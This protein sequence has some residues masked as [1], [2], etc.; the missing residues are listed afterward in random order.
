MRYIIGVTFI[1]FTSIAQSANFQ[2]GV[3]AY[4]KG[5]FKMAYEEFY[6]LAEQGGAVAQYNIG[7]MHENGKAVKQDSKQAVHWYLKAAEQ[8]NVMA[9]F[10]LGT[11]YENGAIEWPQY[12]LDDTNDT[13]SGV[14]LDYKKA[15]YWYRKAAVQGYAQAQ[16]SVGVMY[17]NGQGVNKDI[18]QGVDWYRKAAEQGYAQAQYNLGVA[19]NDGIGVKQEFKQ[20]IHWYSK[21]AEQ[22]DALAQ[23]NLGVMYAKGQGL[24]QDYKTAYMWLN[25]SRYNGFKGTKQAFDFLISKMTIE[26]INEAQK[27]SEKCLESNYKDCL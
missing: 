7:L 1:F 22:N 15:M 10:N 9:Q 5:D 14:P 2:K 11:M 23:F 4:Y 13:S 19:Y 25:L 21:A 24:L 3:D 18:K 20:A 17:I 8:G 27:M 16:N 6:Q 12:G 26:R